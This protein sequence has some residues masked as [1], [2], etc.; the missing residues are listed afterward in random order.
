MAPRTPVEEVIAGIWAEMLGVDRVGVGDNF[1]ALGGHSLLSTRMVA[2]V[3]EAFGVDVPLHK[4]F[5]DPT[6]A[7]LARAL[8]ADPAQRTVVEKTA[9]LL[10]RLSDLSDDEVQQ[11]L[12]RADGRTQ[13]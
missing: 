5:T 13:A 2:R 1:F 12:D 9:E 6:V 7:G 3:R 11:A 8:T 4:V 10:I